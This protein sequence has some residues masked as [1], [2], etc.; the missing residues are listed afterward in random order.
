MIKFWF[1]DRGLVVYTIIKNQYMGLCG[2]LNIAILKRRTAAY[3]FK[4]M[5]AVNYGYNINKAKNTVSN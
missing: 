3:L 2:E 4:N 1:N 5:V